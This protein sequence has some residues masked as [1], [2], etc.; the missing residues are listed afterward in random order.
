MDGVDEK[1]DADNDEKEEIL[2][3]KMND[4]SYLFRKNVYQ[5]IEKR[6]EIFGLD[7]RAC[8]LRMICEVAHSEVIE[9][10]GVVGNLFHILF[11]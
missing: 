9:S 3:R 6:L 8:L 11:T 4:L 5:M 7:G 1:I 2:A 10:N